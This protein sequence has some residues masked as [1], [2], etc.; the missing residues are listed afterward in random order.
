MY[1]LTSR[2]DSI[3]HLI[4]HLNS[5]P[6]HYSMQPYSEIPEMFASYYLHR[7]LLELWNIPSLIKE[8]TGA[9]DKKKRHVCFQLYINLPPCKLTNI[10]SLSLPFILF[11]RRT[12]N[13]S[14]QAHFCLSQWCYL[15]DN[16]LVQSAPFSPS[17]SELL[18][19]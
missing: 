9:L 2:R 18:T 13:L 11:C 1:W 12:R 16:L 19:G 7:G 15:S 4:Y 17:D 6:E 8:C 10:S 3:V 14:L 5:I